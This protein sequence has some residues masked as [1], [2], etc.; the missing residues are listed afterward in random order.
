MLGLDGGKLGHHFLDGQTGPDDGEWLR[1]GRR[2]IGRML[3]EF[4]ELLLQLADLASPAGPAGARAT[5]LPSPCQAVGAPRS[6]QPAGQTHS[7]HIS[8]AV[9]G[10]IASRE[11]S[12]QASCCKASLIEARSDRSFAAW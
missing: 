5:Y 11:A 1:L 7:E 6:C 3:G 12:R 4:Q 2:W 9:M 8:A 10:G